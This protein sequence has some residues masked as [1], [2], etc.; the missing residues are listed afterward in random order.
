MPPLLI[1]KD[2]VQIVIHSREHVPPHVHARYGDDEALVN[3]GTGELI[4]GFIPNKKL[5]LVQAWLAQGTNRSIVEQNFY[6]LN[7]K[8]KPT[9][10]KSSGSSNKSKRV[11]K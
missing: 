11:K 4:E 1:E 7:P 9:G 8:L 5:K 10:E 2:G 6:E 3:I